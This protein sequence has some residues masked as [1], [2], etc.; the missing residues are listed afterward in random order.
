VIE[1]GGIALVGGVTAIVA[2]AVFDR[3]G[4]TTPYDVPILL[5]GAALALGVHYVFKKLG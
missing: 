4:Q 2:A 3:A 1:A 5:A